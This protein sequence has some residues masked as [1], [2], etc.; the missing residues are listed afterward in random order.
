MS[1]PVGD[2][3]EQGSLHTEGSCIIGND[4]LA[5]DGESIVVA[6]I[7]WYT[8]D[9]QILLNLGILNF[10]KKLRGRKGEDGSVVPGR[11]T[12]R[13][14]TSKVAE[15]YDLLCKMTPITLQMKLDLHELFPRK[16][17]W[18]DVIPENLRLLWESHFELIQEI[19]Q[20][21]YSRAI[22]PPD[23]ASLNID[24]LGFGD[25][26]QS[27]ACVSIH[28]RFKRSNVSYSCQLVLSRS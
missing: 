7:R 14:C 11:L 23:A 24:T 18:D 17:D 9:D 8:K 27:A 6:D 16:L 2:S 21:K 12:R 25:A 20:L 28:A 19:N 4:T 10:T 5:D 3:F 26:S 15:I 13:R 1:S 22:I